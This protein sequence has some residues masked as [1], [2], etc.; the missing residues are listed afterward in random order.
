MKKGP[1][2]LL[3]I[4]VVLIGVGI[5]IFSTLGNQTT[6]KVSSVVGE[7][8]KVKGPDATGP[9]RP[10]QGV[11]QYSVTGHEKITRSAINIDR[12]LPTSA[13]ALVYNL[14]SG[15]WE[16]KTNFSDQ[17]IEVARYAMK[18]D[19]AYLVFARTV[20]NV[21]PFT[22]TKDRDWVPSLLRDPSNAKPG[23]TTTGSYAAGK[24]LTMKV[25]TTVLP[26]APVDVG[27]T[28][29]PA[30]VVKF[31]QIASGEYTGNRTETFWWSKDG[32]LLRYTIDSSLK[33]STNLDM[34]ADQRLRSLTPTT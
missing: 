28:K 11:Y 32:L 10:P 22:V 13:V 8:Q 31:D 23:T 21:G 19:G 1:A 15:E 14:P 6:T 30:T 16:V 18:P 7:F 26:P 29:V 3:G 33:G 25:T 2:I 20:L 5:W 9:G 4:L 17:H 24:D 27:G 34:T 12:D